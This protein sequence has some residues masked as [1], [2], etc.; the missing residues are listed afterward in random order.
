[1]RSQ[2]M[3]VIVHLV[4]VLALVDNSHDPLKILRKC[5]SGLLTGA[6]LLYGYPMRY[7]VSVHEHHARSCT[8]ILI[9]TLL[10]A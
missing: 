5:V 3:F 9:G 8:Y 1:M 6:D 2:D 4:A 10:P 7:F